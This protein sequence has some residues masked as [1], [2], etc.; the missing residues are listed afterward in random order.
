MSFLQLENK[1]I[2]LFGLSN[3]KSIASHIAQVLIREK[4]N[5]I[6]VVRSQNARSAIEKLFP[7][8]P[9][10][11]CDVENEEDILKVKEKIKKDYPVIHGLIHSIAFADYSKG[12]KPFHE[13]LKKDFLRSLDIS[14]FSFIQ[15]A[16]HFKQILDPDASVVV[17]SISSTSMA[18]ENYGFMAPVK[19]ALES[20]VGFLA[21]SFSAFSRIR[22]NA[23]KAGLLKTKS[24]AGIPD[25][26]NNYL[27]AEQLTLRKQAL[28]TEEVANAV[29][30]LLSPASSGM[31][32]S[33][34]VIDGGMSVNYF[35]RQIID[36]VM[37]NG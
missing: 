14:C 21:K 13:T 28:K 10:F 25:Y 30:F 1:N 32:A 31:N 3:K 18:S 6:P 7:E 33:G 20:S 27:Y 29:V 35:D 19:A 15:I 24:S 36:K 37:K 4:A 8:I 34:L 11:H 16:N 17:L 22:F 9:V 12:P 5:V 23:V 2:V 26:V